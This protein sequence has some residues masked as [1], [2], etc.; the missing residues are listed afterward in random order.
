MQRPS[1]RPRS[2]GFCPLAG[3]K[4]ESSDSGAWSRYFSY[5]EQELQLNVTKSWQPSRFAYRPSESGSASALPSDRGKG[6]QLRAEAVVPPDFIECALPKALL[7]LLPDVCSS[8]S[9]AR[10]LVRRGR[11]SVNAA[12]GRKASCETRITPGDTLK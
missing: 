6:Y 3:S 10:K 2:A 4:G 7:E 9:G 12:S 5:D 11:I 8:A 1:K